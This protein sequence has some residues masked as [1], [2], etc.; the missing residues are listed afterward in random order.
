MYRSLMEGT[1]HQSELFEKGC[2]DHPWNDRYELQVASSSVHNLGLGSPR[3]VWKI[4]QALPLL[5][6]ILLYLRPQTCQEV[7]PKPNGN[8]RRREEY[9]GGGAARW[10]VMEEW[11]LGVVS[12]TVRE[13]GCGGFGAARSAVRVFM[14]RCESDE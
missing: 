5:S 10:S 2:I 1:D 7:G 14:V 6:P 8:R 12:D 4:L 3:R 11:G 13:G 9:I